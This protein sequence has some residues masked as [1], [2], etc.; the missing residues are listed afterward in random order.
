MPRGKKITAEQ[1]IGKFRESEVGLAHG[2][3][4]PEVVRKLGVNEQT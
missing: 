3:T 2:N 1:I 4:V